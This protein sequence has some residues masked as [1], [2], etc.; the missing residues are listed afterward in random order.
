MRSW[1]SELSSGTSYVF[2]LTGENAVESLR[3]L[4]GPYIPEVARTLSPDSIRARFGVDTVRN[5][6]HCT[7]LPLDGPLESKF[8]FH[9]L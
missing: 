9:V 6:V 4:C 3:Q 7:D 1:V 5:G 8:L 2:E